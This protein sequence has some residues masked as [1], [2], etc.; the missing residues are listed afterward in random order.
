MDNIEIIMSE[1]SISDTDKQAVIQLATELDK[2]WNQRDASA[3]ADLFEE[4]ADVRFYPGAW[5]KGKTAIEAFWHE[6]V[7]PGM[8]GIMQITLVK[9][10][11]FV[12]DNIAIGDGTLR[13]VKIVEGQE[14]V[15]GEREFSNIA[16]K[17][18]GHWY[19]SAGRV[20]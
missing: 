5:V 10:V 4:D 14:Q 2:R 12:A 11:R 15:D 20:V 7:F 3:F 13:Y 6:E 16:V 1:K 18:S 9:R 17:K 19:I 8:P